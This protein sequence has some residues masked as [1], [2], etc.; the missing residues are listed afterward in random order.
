MENQHE[1]PINR[2]AARIHEQNKRKGFYDK[3]QDIGRMIALIHSELSEALEADRDDKYF[4]KNEF[5]EH[6][7]LGLE[8][9]WEDNLIDQFKSIF[10]GTVK[11][12]FEDELADVLIRTLDLAAHLGIDIETHID[13]KMKYNSTREKRH[14]RKY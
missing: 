10:E 13:L 6:H 8:M 2:L 1:E 7:I 4:N 5:S 3:P 14:D 9:L 11:N 12:T